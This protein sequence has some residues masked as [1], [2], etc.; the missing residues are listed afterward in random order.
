MKTRLFFLG[1]S[2]V[3]CAVLAGCG[4]KVEP[5]FFPSAPVSGIRINGV[6]WAS[7]NVDAPGTFADNP[8][9]PGMYYQWGQKVGW[10]AANPAVPSDGTSEWIDYYS[11]AYNDDELPWPAENDPCPSGWRLP[12]MQDFAALCDT[13]SVTR[14]TIGLTGGNGYST[15]EGIKFTDKLT[16]R[17]MFLPVAG[18]R[19]NASLLEQINYVGLYWSSTP[20]GTDMG[21]AMSLVGSGA[22]PAGSS[23]YY[24][25][26][27]IRCV[28]K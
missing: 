9:D 13:K 19:Y 12:E 20:N 14:E 17:S 8:K 11:D 2:A 24:Y 25:G 22:S 5:Q 15:F 7:L 26:L 28:A 21:Y 16:G 1:L 23:P 10:S 18:Y 3:F 6:V 4:K 27:S